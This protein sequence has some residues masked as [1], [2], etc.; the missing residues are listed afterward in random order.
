MPEMVFVILLVAAAVA[1]FV[2]GRASCLR[3]A[4]ACDATIDR[5]CHVLSSYGHPVDPDDIDASFQ[6]RLFV[7]PEN[8]RSGS[9]V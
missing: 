9:R 6:P 5:L 2:A 3:R 1:G 4:R 8:P 7:P